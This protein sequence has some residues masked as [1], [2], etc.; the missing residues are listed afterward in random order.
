M[1][2]HRPLLPGQARLRRLLLPIRPNVDLVPSAAALGADDSAFEVWDLRFGRVAP[3]FNQRAIEVAWE[4]CPLGLRIFEE[5][6]CVFGIRRSLLL[7]PTGMGM[8][9]MAYAARDNS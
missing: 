6:I 9:R 2:G 4:K 5:V 1:R 7:G 3:D 8:S